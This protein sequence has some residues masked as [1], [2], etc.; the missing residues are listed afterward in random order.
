M[1]KRQIN[2]FD[3]GRVTN[4]AFFRQ[5]GLFG[6]R[7]ERNP[8]IKQKLG[9]NYLSWRNQYAVVDISNN[10]LRSSATTAKIVAKSKEVIAIYNSF[11]DIAKA[12]LKNLDKVVADSASNVVNV[13]ENRGKIYN[14]GINEKMTTVST[15]LQDFNGEYK[16]DIINIGG[17]K[18]VEQLDKVNNEYIDLYDVRIDQDKKKI[19][20]N[21]RSAR[22]KLTDYYR[23]LVMIINSLVFIEGEEQYGEFIDEINSINKKFGVKRTAAKEEDETDE[24]PVVDNNDDNMF[25]DIEEDDEE[26]DKEIDDEVGEEADDEEEYPEAIEWVEKFGVA[27]ATN[28]MIFYVMVDGEKVFYRLIDNAG[29]GFIPGGDRYQECWEKL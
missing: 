20:I 4:K 15:T 18:W 17:E 6:K 9:D 24:T 12:N 26:D 19:N 29:V 27:N 7:V 21:M 16:Q 13:F 2:Q 3:I 5:Q 8:F 23:K 14:M 22:T 1:A 11:H 28:G 10:L 25:D